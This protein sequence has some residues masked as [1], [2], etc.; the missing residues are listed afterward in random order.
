[1]AT[2]DGICGTPPNGRLHGVHRNRY[3]WSKVTQEATDVGSV[4]RACH[5][6]P[7]IVDA[8]FQL[9]AFIQT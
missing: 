7:S 4:S 2:R 8:E 6:R 5:N 3:V 9:I 1:V